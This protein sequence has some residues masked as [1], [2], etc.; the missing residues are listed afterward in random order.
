MISSSKSFHL[1]VDH[2]RRDDLSYDIFTSE[3]G[4]QVSPFTTSSENDMGLLADEDFLFQDDPEALTANPGV[5]IAQGSSCGQPS[6]KRDTPHNDL[7]LSRQ[8]S[9]SHC[10]KSY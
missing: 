3:N 4:D 8:S 1:N 7:I 2:K 5:E 10:S 6:R 9:F